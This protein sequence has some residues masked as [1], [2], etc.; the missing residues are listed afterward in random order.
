MPSV[1]KRVIQPWRKNE[2]KRE[3]TRKD[4]FYQSVDWRKLRNHFIQEHPLC[5]NCNNKGIIQEAEM[6]DHILP[7]SQGGNKLDSKNLQSLCNKCHNRKSNS[8]RKNTNK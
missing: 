5:S 3:T 7:I 8:E 2:P 6:V 1:P 4:G